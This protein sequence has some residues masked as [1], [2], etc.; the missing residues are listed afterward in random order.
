MAPDGT[1]VLVPVGFLSVHEMDPQPTDGC[2]HSVVRRH[3]EH[4]TTGNLG[5]ELSTP[6]A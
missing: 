4:G 5:W 3:C 6:T 2:V 1:G